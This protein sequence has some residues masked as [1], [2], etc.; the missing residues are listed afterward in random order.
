M[1][2]LALKNASAMSTP[3]LCEGALNPCIHP[4][5][6]ADRSD[7]GLHYDMTVQHA[8]VCIV[9]GFAVAKNWFAPLT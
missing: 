7:D 9:K 8:V 4:A 2:Q 5:G 1:K 6:A 3:S